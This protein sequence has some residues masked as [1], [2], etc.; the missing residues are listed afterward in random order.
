MKARAPSFERIRAGVLVG[1]AALVVIVLVMGRFTG[2]P[3]GP[4]RRPPVTIRIGDDTAIAILAAQF[5][6]Y[7]FWLPARVC[8]LGGRIEGASG[9]DRGFEAGVLTDDEFRA[10]SASPQAPRL[11][12]GR[13]AA[14]APSITLVG[15]GRYH[16]VVSNFFSPRSV[17]VVTVK[18]SVV[19]P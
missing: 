16:L 2:G 7:L 19:C 12:S 6:Q 5:H 10:W 14:W 13:V 4:P 11:Q 1:V 3:G 17:R 18:A 15:P 9:P 8:T